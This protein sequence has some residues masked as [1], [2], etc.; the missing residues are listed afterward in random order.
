MKPRAVFCNKNLHNVFD[1]SKV[2]ENGSYKQAFNNN[3]P[4]FNYT[5]R[6]KN[7]GVVGH[8]TRIL[9][10]EWCFNFLGCLTTYKKYSAHHFFLVSTNNTLHTACTL[11][12]LMNRYK[13]VAKDIDSRVENKLFFLFKHSFAHTCARRI[14]ISFFCYCP[15][16][17]DITLQD[18]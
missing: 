4:F 11:V 2:F 14:D 16:S 7:N 8:F 13:M 15:I 10:L 5:F 9:L 17:F 12:G 18:F 3:K 1:K 6:T